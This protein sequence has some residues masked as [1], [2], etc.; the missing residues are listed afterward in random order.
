MALFEVGQAQGKL[1]LLDGQAK[2]LA[3]M[4]GDKQVL[5][6]ATHPRIPA[7]QKKAALATRLAGSFDPLL[8]NLI[9]L[10]I[11]K[12]RVG[13]LLEILR[14]FDQLTD[15]AS[16]VEGVTIV[17]AVPLSDEQQREIVAGIKRFSAYGE[18]RVQTKVDPA[19]LGGVEVRLGDNLVLDGTVASRLR[20]LRD[21]LYKYRHRGLGA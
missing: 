4:V 20:Q 9:R 14:W 2:Q 3:Q 16:G 17:S 5:Q 7:E 11:D 18:L 6:F 12:K 21:R 8:L 15:A 1:E 13:L 19:L 10:L